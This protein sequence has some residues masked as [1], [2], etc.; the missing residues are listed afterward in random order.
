MKLKIGQLKQLIRETAADYDLQSLI[1][2]TQALYLTAMP[3]KGHQ[4]QDE[5]LI[6]GPDYRAVVRSPLQW[7]RLLD[8]LEKQAL[9]GK[10]ISYAGWG[11]DENEYAGQLVPGYRQIGHHN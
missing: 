1:Q 6:V 5:I 9:A 8:Q 10:Q 11:E 2:R 7:S 4:G 3:R